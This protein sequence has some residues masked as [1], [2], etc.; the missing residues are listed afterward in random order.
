MKLRKF[1][2]LS[3]IVVLLA[4]SA[5][6]ASAEPAR[7]PLLNAAADEAVPGAYIVVFKAEMTAQAGV[8][9][10]MGQVH[11]L[12]VTEKYVYQD[13]IQGFA[14]TLSD[15][16][17]A[18]LRQSPAV[19]YVEEDQVV[20]ISA[21][22]QRNVTWGL[23]RISQRKLPLNNVFTFKSTGKGV[24][25]YIIDTGIT[26]S[27]ADFSGRAKVGMDAMNDGQNGVDC[28]GHG[29][30]V[31]GTIGGEIYGVAK[32][33]N[34][35]AVRVLDC[36]GSGTVSSVVAGIDWVTRNHEGRKP[37]VANMS[38]GGMPSETLDSAI[39]KSIEDG[40]TYVVAAGNNGDDAC[41]SSPARVKEAVTVGATDTTDTRAPWSNFGSCLDIFAPGVGITSDWPDNTQHELSGTSMASPHV[42]GVAALY[43]STHPGASPSEVRNRLV[44][45]AT[46]NV[47]KDAG[48]GSPEILVFEYD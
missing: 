12:G 3:I 28:H 18:A 11:D 41:S 2:L 21:S 35:V 39:K 30:H 6:P 34:L 43:L 23:D 42:A 31:A 17:L 29:T 27:H 32:D 38:L 36:F 20:K 46:K 25:A 10:L 37:A 44:G 16:A 45:N 22:R 47:V 33:V 24:T 13:A 9:Q 26:P 19:A 1:W 15:S 48:E 7:A 5:I 8:E 40:I 14:A 4:S